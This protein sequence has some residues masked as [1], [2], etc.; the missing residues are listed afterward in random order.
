MGQFT[1][2]ANSGAG[3]RDGHARRGGLPH[4]FS[5][6][7]GQAVGLVDEVAEVALA[8]EFL[9]PGVGEF[10]DGVELVEGFDENRAAAAGR[11]EDAETLKFLLPG[12]PEANEGLALRLVEGGQVVGIG[13]GQGLAGGAGGGAFRSVASPRRP[14]PARPGRG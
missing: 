4:E 13:I 12:F 2:L 10:I 11:V 8:A 9:Q 1:R 7:R 6:R 3:R 5:F 14:A